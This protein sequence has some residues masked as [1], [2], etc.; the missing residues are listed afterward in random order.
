MK[1]TEL[2]RHTT[3]KTCPNQLLQ[4]SNLEVLQRKN[5]SITLR[6]ARRDDQNGYII[7]IFGVQNQKIFVAERG[8]VKRV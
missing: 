1:T 5:Q 6:R 3:P 4:K 2:A 7:A 8:S